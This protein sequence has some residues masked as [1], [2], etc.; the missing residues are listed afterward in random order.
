MIMKSSNPHPNDTMESS[1]EIKNSARLKPFSRPQS[2]SRS[3]GRDRK[4]SRGFGKHPFAERDFR[5]LRGL[6]KNW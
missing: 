5:D 1:A 6:Q 3:S 2:K 4:Q